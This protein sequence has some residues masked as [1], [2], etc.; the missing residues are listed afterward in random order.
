MV[1]GFMI[2]PNKVC[3]HE[4]NNFLRFHFEKTTLY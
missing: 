1:N 3:D 4:K 2:F